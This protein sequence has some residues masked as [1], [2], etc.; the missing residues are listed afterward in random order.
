M[1]KII[2]IALDL[3]LGRLLHVLQGLAVGIGFSI[4]FRSHDR[5]EGLAD[6]EFGQFLLGVS[7]D[8]FSLEIGCPALFLVGIEG[9][10]SDGF[11][12]AGRDNNRRLGSAWFGRHLV[13][14]SPQPGWM[15]LSCKSAVG[16]IN[17]TRAK[18]ETHFSR[19]RAA[20]IGEPEY[21]QYARRNN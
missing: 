3:G 18:G 2:A 16:L 8:H 19:F 4:R 13:A 10:L 15:E 7:H 17:E 21:D 12:A 6:D 20:K 1:N 11:V 14:V 9:S 5:I